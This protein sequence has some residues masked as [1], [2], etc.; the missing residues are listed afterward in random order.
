MRESVVF[1]RHFEELSNAGAAEVPGIKPAAV[2]RSVRAIRRLKDV[3]WGMRG[4]IEVIW[5]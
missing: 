3:L 1:L 4:G 2:N 5:G